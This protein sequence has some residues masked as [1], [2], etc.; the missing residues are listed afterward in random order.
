MTFLL[1]ALWP[2]A[3]RTVFF[4]VD[5]YVRKRA[6]SDGGGGVWWVAGGDVIASTRC[7]TLQGYLEAFPLPEIRN[8][9]ERDL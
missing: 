1:D 5:T 2:C 9:R 6:Y 4:L 8:R 7:A 3:V